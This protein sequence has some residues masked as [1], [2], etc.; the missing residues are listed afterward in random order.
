MSAT[1]NI[2]DGEFTHSDLPAPIASVM[3]RPYPPEWWYVVNGRLTHSALPPPP[4]AGAFCG[5]TSLKQ[6][7]IPESV[8]SIGEFAFA[9][10]ALTRVKIASDCT[11]YPTSFP[12]GCVIEFYDGGD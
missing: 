4:K 10:T 9:D 1:W 12:D 2:I 7:S 5:C 11:Y 8:K 3:V 6:V